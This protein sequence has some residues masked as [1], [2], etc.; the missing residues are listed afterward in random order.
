MNDRT[1][2]LEQNRTARETYHRVFAQAQSNAQQ[3]KYGTFSSDGTVQ[4][5]MGSDYRIRAL[6]IHPDV[7]DEIGE[8]QLKAAVVSA[9]N[10]ARRA[11]HHGQRRIMMHRLGLVT[12]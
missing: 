7:V 2:W 10:N 3:R 12:A 1:G 9:Y 4:A 8:D 6:E 5:V 11:V